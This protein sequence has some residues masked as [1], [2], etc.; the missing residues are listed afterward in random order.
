MT[1]PLD[2]KAL[3]AAKDLVSKTAEEIRDRSFRRGPAS[4]PGAPHRCGGCDFLGVCGMKEAVAHKK[5]N[6]KKW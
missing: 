2:E 5:S 3:A 1:V 4:K 6:P